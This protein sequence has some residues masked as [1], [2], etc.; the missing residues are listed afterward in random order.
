MKHCNSRTVSSQYNWQNL[1]QR[2]ISEMFGADSVVVVVS[3]TRFELYA[4]L[5]QVPAR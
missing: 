1:F 3:A 4:G 5:N 2:G